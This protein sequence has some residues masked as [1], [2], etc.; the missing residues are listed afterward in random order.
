MSCP[1]S[2]YIPDCFLIQ[3]CIIIQY[4][5]TRPKPHRQYLFSSRPRR[6]SADSPAKQEEWE[7]VRF[8]FLLEWSQVITPYRD[9]SLSHSTEYG[10]ASSTYL[11]WL[12]VT[13]PYRETRVR[14]RSHIVCFAFFLV[15]SQVTKY[16]ASGI[17][18]ICKYL[19]TPAQRFFY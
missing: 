2:K 10:R 18:K 5:F 6:E 15:W 8:A 13:I 17:R 4:R 12:R 7:I 14:F 9:A 3:Y 1:Q 19:P 11:V 16:F